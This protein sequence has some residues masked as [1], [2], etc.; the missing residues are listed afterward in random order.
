MSLLADDFYAKALH[1]RDSLALPTAHPQELKSFRWE[2]VKLLSIFYKF[3]K[4]KDSSE[5]WN[6]QYYSIGTHD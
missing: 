3:D 5:I 4:T 6:M 1:A 2:V